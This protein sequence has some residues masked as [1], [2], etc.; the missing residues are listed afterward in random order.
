MSELSQYPDLN[1]RIAE[2]L[3]LLNLPVPPHDAD[4]FETGLLD[5]LMFVELLVLIEEKLDM[6]FSI[7]DLERENFRSI[8]HIT[9]FVTG[10]QR[11]RTAS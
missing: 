5:S 3:Q 8:D 10:R 7:D 4:L 11:I 9:S 1:Q 6:S 2:M